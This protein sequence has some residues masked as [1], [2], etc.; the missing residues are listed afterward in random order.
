MGRLAKGVNGAEGDVAVN[1]VAA[2]DVKFG[3]NES[4]VGG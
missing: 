4:G 3:D 1:K 2:L